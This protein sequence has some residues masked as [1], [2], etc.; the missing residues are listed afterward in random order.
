MT[1]PI[2]SYFT[3]FFSLSEMFLGPKVEQ[4]VDRGF[5]FPPI[6]YNSPFPVSEEDKKDQKSPVSE[7]KEDEEVPEQTKTYLI[8]KKLKLLI[9]VRDRKDYSV[10]L[11]KDCVEEEKR[12]KFKISASGVDLEGNIIDKKVSNSKISSQY[13]IDRIF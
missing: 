12:K 4:R 8:L 6:T 2:K 7:D 5:D 9:K 1:L 13:Y 10:Q 11:N 3:I